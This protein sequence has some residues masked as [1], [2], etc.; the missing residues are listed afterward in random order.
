M[1][2]AQSEGAEGSRVGQPA[3]SRLSKVR[4]QL[5]LPSWL[6]PR[7]ILPQCLVSPAVLRTLLVPG[8]SLIVSRFWVAAPFFFFPYHRQ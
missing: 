5:R 3:H 4:P 6:P 2:S 1:P 7:R 8:I